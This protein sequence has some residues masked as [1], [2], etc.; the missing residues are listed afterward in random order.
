MEIRTEKNGN[1]YIIFL[2]GVLDTKTAPELREMLSVI[3]EGTKL[4]TMDFGELEYLT[5]A[6]LRVLLVAT[7]DMQDLGGTMQLKNM[8]EEIRGIFNNTGFCD[9]L[10]VI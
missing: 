3:P 4:L 9:V 5:S 1:E 8:N 10:D 6:G 2:E 7:Q